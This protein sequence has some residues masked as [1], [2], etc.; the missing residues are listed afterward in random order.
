[1]AEALK[2]AKLAE[3][4]YL[5]ARPRDPHHQGF[6]LP[7]IVRM[8][9]RSGI[10]IAGDDPWMTVRS[11]LNADQAHWLNNDA[12]WIPI[13][14]VRQVGTELSGRALS[15]A[16]YP[17]VQQRYTTDRVFHYE[18]AKEAML[19]SGVRIKGSATGPTMRK[20]LAGS[21]DR[22]EPTGRR[23]YWRWKESGT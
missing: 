11:A 7:D 4:A 21:P 6:E 3:S 20:A 22:F 10:Q 1:M 8:L 17:F 13:E 14:E 18:T 12:N 15:D 16:I 5:L 23:G 19:K 9:E 2:G